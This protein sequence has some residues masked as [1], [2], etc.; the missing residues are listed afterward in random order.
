[1]RIAVL[2]L[3]YVWLPLAYHFDKVWHSVVWFDI[4]EK[5]LTDLKNGI[6]ITR[7]IWEK[8]KDSNILF[9][10]NSE[11]LKN[12]EVLIVTVPTPINENK[13]PDYTPL[14]K[15]SETIGKILQKWQIVVYESTVDPG[16][17]EEIC[18]PVLE[19]FSNLKCPNDF[20]IWYSPERINPGDKE[21]TVDKIKKVNFLVWN[22]IL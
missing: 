3:G 8:I 21:H 2:W 19:K 5:R 20:K 7:E 12:S 13:D 22:Y 9:T 6:D 10:S 11:D 17:T 15:A 4:S 14:I 16:A 1:M 18:L